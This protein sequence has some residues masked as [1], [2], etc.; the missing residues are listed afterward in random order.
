[1]VRALSQV[2]I[3]ALLGAA[4]TG[5]LATA[6]LQRNQPVIY[7]NP[8]V[9]NAMETGTPRATRNEGSLFDPTAGFVSLWRDD[10]AQA[11]GDLVTVRISINHTAEGTA[12]TD[13]D[14]ESEI[15]AGITSFL[16]YEGKLPGVQYGALSNDPLNSTSP[17]QLID[18]ESVSRFKG[19]GGTKRTGKLTADVSA[20]VTHV[21]PN[22]NMLIHGSQSLLINN[23]NSLL[24]V[25][26]LIRPGDLSF[27]NIVL[28]N[29]IANARIEITGRGV[30]SDKQRPGILMRAFDW[31]W[32][33]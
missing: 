23:E 30:V 31:L 19:E 14:R 21:Y 26:G 24:T 6:L 29:R 5:C 16:G 22:G 3:L 25:D 27:D 28:S 7:E 11:V 17:A 18:S 32:P 15:R 12:A 10:T 8:P 2:S 4:F 9:V 33:L 13:L 1:M 20:V